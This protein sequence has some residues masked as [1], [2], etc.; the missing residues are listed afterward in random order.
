MQAHAAQAYAGA[1]KSA[2]AERKALRQ[3]HEAWRSGEALELAHQQ[4]A[5]QP[6]RQQEL[7]L[8][9][10]QSM[11]QQEQEHSAEQGKAQA[12]WGSIRGQQPGESAGITTATEPGEDRD[13]GG[14]PAPA[15]G[16]A[17]LWDLLPMLPALWPSMLASG[18]LPAHLQEQLEQQQ[19][20]GSGLGPGQHM[21]GSRSRSPRPDPSV[22]GGE[23]ESQHAEG[24]EPGMAQGVNM[25][26]PGN[27]GGSCHGVCDW[28]TAG[29][30]GGSGQGLRPSTSQAL[31]VTEQLALLV[32]HLRARH[33]YCFWCGA[34]YCSTQE[35]ADGCPGEG[36]EDH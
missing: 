29:G 28:D 35:L 12:L 1:A 18:Q 2:F 22:A 27:P 7:E 16:T 13:E 17:C 21:H 34:Q 5:Q 8:A 3:L 26:E 23:E 10:R 25:Q 33:L 14:S 20:D 6:T 32:R 19:G 9:Q 31:P 24:C 30:D 15:A 36:E 4:A 11:Q